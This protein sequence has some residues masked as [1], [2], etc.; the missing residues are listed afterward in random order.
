VDGRVF[1]QLHILDLKTKQETPLVE[2]RSVDD[3][4]EWLDNDHVLYSLPE[5]ETGSSASTNVWLAPVDGSSD[6]KLFLKKA[7]SPSVAAPQ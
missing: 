4:L 1:W 7:Y 5:T 3:Q 2:K 6:P